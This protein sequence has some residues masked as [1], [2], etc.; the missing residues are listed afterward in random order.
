MPGDGNPPIRMPAR[1]WRDIA[2][3]LAT[4][5]NQRRSLELSIELNCALDEQFGKIEDGL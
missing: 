5:T 1:P 2:K 4:E 3:E